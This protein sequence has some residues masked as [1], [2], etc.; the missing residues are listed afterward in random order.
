MRQVV[1]AIG[2][3]LEGHVTYSLRHLDFLQLH[4][5]RFS[6]AVG[7]TA[8]A[9]AAVAVADT[10]AVTAGSVMRA[11]V[12]A[13]VA[14]LVTTGCDGAVAV[15]T[16]AAGGASRTTSGAA[17]AVVVADED[18]TEAVGNAVE[19]LVPRCGGV[20]R[21][22]SPRG[23]VVAPAPG[24]RPDGGIDRDFF[25]F[26]DGVMTSVDDATGVDTA[27]RDGAAADDARGGV[28]CVE[29]TEYDDVVRGSTLIGV[30][31][32]DGVWSSSDDCGLAH[33]S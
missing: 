3:A 17:A 20:R 22:R 30:S 24:V 11:C 6:F 19:M 26:D 7:A 13:G 15:V 5:A 18:G 31:S 1:N 16:G 28:A 25:Q 2:K 29:S 23:V 32:A 12:G 10:L 27:N 8:A 33:A 21:V 4:G 9:A 14:V